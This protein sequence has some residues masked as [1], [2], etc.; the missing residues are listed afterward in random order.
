MRCRPEEEEDAAVAGAVDFNRK[1]V[2]YMPGF[3]GTGPA[4]MGPMTG[5]GRGFCNPSGAAYGPAPAWG[6]GYSGAGY[7]MGFGRGRDFSGGYRPGFGR[8]FRP[9]VGGGRGYGRGIGR[10]GSYPARGGW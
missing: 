7:G 8:G 1:E 10:R 4:G 6:P 9:G 5:G 3:N 2:F